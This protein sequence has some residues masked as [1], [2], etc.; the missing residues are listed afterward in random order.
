MGTRSIEAELDSRRHLV[1]VLAAGPRG[2]ERRSRIA[3]LSS[4]STPLPQSILAISHP[5]PTTRAVLAGIAPGCN[6]FVAALRIGRKRALSRMMASGGPDQSWETR[7]HRVGTEP[8]RSR[9]THLEAVARRIG[10]RAHSKRR[11]VFLSPHGDGA[12]ASLDQC[13]LPA[14][15]VHERLADLQRAPRALLGQ[16]SDFDHPFVS[17]TAKQDNARHHQG[18]HANRHWHFN[19]TGVL[20]AST[21][22]VKW[23]RA[24]FLLGPRFP[25]P[26]WLAM[27][28]LWHFFF[29]WLFVINGVL[30][31]PMRSSRRISE[32]SA[33]EADRHQSICRGKSSITRGCVS[34]RRGG[35]D[36]NALQKIDLFHRDLRS[37]SARGAD[38]PHHVADDGRVVSV[39]AVGFRRA[40]K[41]THDPFHLRV[42]V[43]R[44][45]HR[46]HRHGGAVGHLE[47]YPLDDHRPYAIEPVEADHG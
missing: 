35:E 19:T 8:G 13:A 39:P 44:F 25:V 7:R 31:R 40:A 45:L 23:R 34:Q 3:R 15:H 26:Q 5:D 37:G 11:A 10:G 47:Q 42:L 17:L 22:T 2:P 43:S 6:A 24:A 9:F 1:D 32:G 18:H 41:R 14:R 46:P 20:G 21:P 38:R 28:R 4:I 12:F 30:S 27:G 29:A 16:I 33:A 36:Y